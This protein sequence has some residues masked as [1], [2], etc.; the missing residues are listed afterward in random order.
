MVASAPVVANES[1]GGFTVTATESVSGTSGT[2]SLLNIAQVFLP[3]TNCIFCGNF[4]DDFSNPQSGWHVGEDAYVRSDYYA[5]EY[6]VLTKSDQFIYLFKAP[7]CVPQTY[8][9][10]TNVRWVD[11]IGEYYGILLNIEG[12]F[13]KFYVLVVNAEQQ[14][15]DFILYDGST[16]TPLHQGISAA[17]NS[18]TNSNHVKLIS[19]GY[20]VV[21]ELNQTRIGDWYFSDPI[22]PISAG[23]IV[24][25][26]EGYDRADAR[27]D[28][29]T[30]NQ[31]T[32]SESLEESGFPP[33]MQ[34]FQTVEAR[35]RL[36]QGLLV[37]PF[38][39]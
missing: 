27:F 18:G 3:N 15:F 10:E 5:G 4:F 31:Q 16:I 34:H 26:Y 20:S 11:G 1:P 29:Y 22:L 38:Y 19:N 39:P 24:S 30:I 33:N 9:I 2:Y 37:R 6:R 14:T 32:F 23:I 25:P 17:I 13:G 21:V 7:A 36:Q 12:D 28:N 35:Q 8:A